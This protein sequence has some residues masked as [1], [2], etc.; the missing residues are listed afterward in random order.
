M[1]LQKLKEDKKM[2][3]LQID[4]THDLISRCTLTQMILHLIDITVIIVSWRDIMT[5]W[6][7]LA[8]GHVIPVTACH[9]VDV[10]V[11]YIV[12]FISTADH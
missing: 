8:N 2:N 10:Y 1:L 6:Y 9:S 5:I 12:Y 7:A 3:N 11:Q 4:N